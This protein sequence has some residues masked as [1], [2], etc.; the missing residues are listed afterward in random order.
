VAILFIKC[1]YQYIISICID[2]LQ[3]ISM[4]TNTSQYSLMTAQ[5]NW[6]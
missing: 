3:Y 1:L 6:K 2:T 5:R 4:P